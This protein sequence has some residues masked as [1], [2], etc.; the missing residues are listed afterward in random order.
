MAI[1]RECKEGALVFQVKQKRERKK[2]DPVH[3]YI[4]V[5]LTTCLVYWKQG[6]ST[7]LYIQRL[8]RAIS[9]KSSP[10]YNSIH[11]RPIFSQPGIFC[12]H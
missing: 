10:H 5:S 9:V 3:L 4:Y 7:F 12:E 1:R 2:E 8:L 6:Q 11:K